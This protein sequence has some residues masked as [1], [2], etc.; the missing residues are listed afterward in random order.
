MNR[1][2]IRHALA[3][4]LTALGLF[5]LW[6]FACRAFAV[7]EMI[8]PAPSQIIHSM[9][10]YWSVIQAEALQTLF[11]TLVGF[12]LAIV[13]GV[14][15]GV[16]VGASPEI[17][18]AINPLM[19]GFNSIP[20]VAI[21]PVLV[22]WF[23]IGTVPA[24]LCAFL[25]AFFP[26]AVN[27]A[28]GIAHLEPEL[29]DVLRSL[30]ATKSVIL[31]KVALPRALPYLFASLKVAITLAFVGSVVSEMVASNAGI[32]YL[33]LNASSSFRVPLVF[34]ALIVVGIMGILMYAI[35]DFIE[36][37]STSWAKRGE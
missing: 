13:F 23:G 32:G 36:R 5:F 24:V 1:V 16:L 7:P 4:W 28:T 19:I 11:T 20:K 6:E 14:L 35:S 22:M 21:V 8:L 34:A 25:T 26:I 27:V 30:G 33:L 31:K 9:V 3:P 12:A 17:Y 10:Q 18:R 37:R 2:K 29:A 15:L